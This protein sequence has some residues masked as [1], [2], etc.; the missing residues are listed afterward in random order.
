M[1]FAEFAYLIG[2][3]ACP[4]CYEKHCRRDLP[5]GLEALL[6]GRSGYSAE[7][8]KNDQKNQKNNP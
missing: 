5:A 6:A 8:I 3:Q 4:H 1:K 2:R 7:E